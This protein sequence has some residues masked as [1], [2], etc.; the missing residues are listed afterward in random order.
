MARLTVFYDGNRVAHYDIKAGSIRVGRHP[1]SEIF[2]P[3][4]AVSRLQ[5]TVEQSND[6]WMV[7]PAGSGLV[8]LN[9]QE[10][11][12]DTLLLEGALVEFGKY[13]LHYSEEFDE[14][15][16]REVQFD[17]S[18]ALAAIGPVPMP[19]GLEAQEGTSILTLDM[20]DEQHNKATQLTRPHVVW[21][22]EDGEE[23]TLPLEDGGIF[24]GK[25][26]SVHIKIPGGMTIGD[27]HARIVKAAGGFVI[28]PCAWW[29]KIQVN[30]SGVKSSR[31]LQNGDQI[32][33]GGSLI[34]Y[35]TSIVAR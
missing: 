19:T 28:A 17:G 18:A 26:D 35:R 9:S 22:A 16:T 34:V 11:E 32:K 30:N 21:R 10:L 8:Y 1:E 31:A 12:K 5:V 14:T 33:I 20:M 2:L 4:K 24:I 3:D 13:L 29:M 6:G 25:G 15:P 7:K 23:K 27:R